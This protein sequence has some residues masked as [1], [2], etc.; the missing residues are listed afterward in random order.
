[1]M[2]ARPTLAWSGPAV[3]RGGAL[4]GYIYGYT[5]VPFSVVIRLV[6]FR[7]TLSCILNKHGGQ[8]FMVRGLCVDGGINVGSVCEV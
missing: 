5:L 1:M 7:W 6:S 8:T 3:L 2:G 4:N